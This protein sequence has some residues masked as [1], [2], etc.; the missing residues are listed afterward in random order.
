MKLFIIYQGK[1]IYFMRS[2][3]VLTELC[4]ECHIKFYHDPSTDMFYVK[5]EDTYKFISLLVPQYKLYFEY[6]Q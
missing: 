6:I 3:R 4:I 5:K 1:G 2:N